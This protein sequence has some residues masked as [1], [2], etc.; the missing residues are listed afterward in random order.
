MLLLLQEHV[1]LAALC[2]LVFKGERSLASLHPV[3]AM[4]DK[5]G[6][7]GNGR[8]GDAEGEG[9]REGDAGKGGIPP[10]A[11]LRRSLLAERAVSAV[12]TLLKT[13]LEALLES[14]LLA[15]RAVSTVGT[16]LEILLRSIR[17]LASKTFCC[18]C[19]QGR[20]EY[21]CPWVAPPDSELCHS[22]RLL[23]CDSAS[24]ANL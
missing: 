9:G 21:F 13:L 24:A 2:D 17:N 7:D 22:S 4:A 18:M 12:G 20:G 15:E 10:Q 11:N 5:R 6:S 16:L 3:T 1:T 19:K 8:G 23:D 14:S